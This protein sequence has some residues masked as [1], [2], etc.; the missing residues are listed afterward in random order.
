M[1]EEDTHQGQG[2]RGKD[3]QEEEQGQ[4]MEEEKEVTHLTLD[5]F[6]LDSQVRLYRLNCKING[7]VH[8][9][10]FLKSIAQ[11]AVN[12]TAPIFRCASISRLY[13]CER[14]SE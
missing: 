9:F 8:I 3:E 12:E 7:T 5:N 6:H 4:K 14:V 13:P 2:R 1:E 10:F 11:P